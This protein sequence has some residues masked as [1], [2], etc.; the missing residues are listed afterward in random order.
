MRPGERAEEPVPDPAAPGPRYRPR[1][2]KRIRY[3]KASLVLGGV[4]VA[5]AMALPVVIDRV[6]HA[7]DLAALD[8]VASTIPDPPEPEPAAE[9]APA[10]GGARATPSSGCQAY[11]YARCNA[12]GIPASGCAPAVEAAAA[13]P[14]GA[15]MP[16]CRAAVEEAL[17]E[18]ER[19]YAPAQEEPAA[20]AVEDTGPAVAAA[21]VAPTA[22]P[23]AAV[24][25]DVPKEEAA[26]AAPA[27][28]KEG[29]SPADRTLLADRMRVLVEE[30]QRAQATR[31][32]TIPP[33]AMVARIEELRQ[34]VQAEG[35]RE[36]RAI[37]EALIRQRQAAPIQQDS[38]GTVGSFQGSSPTTTPEIDAAQR[39]VEKAR[40]G[41]GLPPP[42]SPSSP[43]PTSISPSSL[44]SVESV[45][46]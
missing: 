43:A 15:P 34:I 8:E 16:A 37:Y 44:P 29:L 3:Y 25:K 9:P 39:I 2:T 18:A 36:A 6:R 45:T 11:V 14:A 28:A 4:F 24:A 27:P 7:R 30:I 5:A 31:D 40:Q 26:V 33:A 12:L 23:D 13:V 1:S 17:K 19:V 32:Y 10:G 38:A 46:P 22:T 41:A 21:P 20:V 35:S 42:A